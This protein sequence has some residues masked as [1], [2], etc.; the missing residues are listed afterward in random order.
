MQVVTFTVRC[1][2]KAD[3]PGKGAV[4]EK[5]RMGRKRKGPS[6]IESLG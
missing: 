2:T 1:A 5:G 4:L 6:V 3:E